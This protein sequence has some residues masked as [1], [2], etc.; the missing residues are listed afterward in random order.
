MI[1]TLLEATPYKKYYI[2]KA[3]GSGSGRHKEIEM[4]DI[5]K[6]I[7]IGIGAADIIKNRIRLD[8]TGVVDMH[9]TAMACTQRTTAIEITGLMFMTCLGVCYQD[10]LFGIANSSRH[11][12]ICAGDQ[13][14]TQKI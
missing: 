14:Q 4:I 2:L 13:C 6:I 3:L 11:I 8:H 5:L 7:E 1:K 9:M 10:D 12:A